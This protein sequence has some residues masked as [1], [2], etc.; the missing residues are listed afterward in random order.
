MVLVNVFG[1]GVVDD[2]VIYV[3]VLEMINYYFKEEFFLVNVFIY[4]CWWEE[5]R[6]YVLDYLVELVVKFVNE[7]GGYGMLMGFSVSF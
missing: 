7:V 5:D 2:K 6:N 4:F 1:M 3:Y